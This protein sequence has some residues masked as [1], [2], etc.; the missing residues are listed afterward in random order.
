MGYMA[1]NSPTVA[2]TDDNNVGTAGGA[3]PFITAETAVKGFTS[4]NTWMRPFFDPIEEYERLA[5]NRPSDRI[6]AELPKVTD[7]TLAAILQEDP[8]RVIQQLA[9]GLVSSI[10]HDDYAQIADIVHRLKLLPMYNRMGTALQKHWNML[11]KARIWGRSASYTFFTSTDGQFH[12][13][14]VIPYVKD[15]IT[16]PGKVYAPDSNVVYMRSWYQKT[17]IQAIIARE[18]WMIKHRKDYKPEWNLTLLQQFLDGGVSTKSAELQT[19]AEK[20]RGADAKGYEVIHA[21]QKGK[22][23]EFYSFSPKF[24]DGATFRTKINPDPRGKIPIDFEY[25]NI[26][27]S[28]PLGRGSVESSG[29]V[30]NLIDQQ[31]Q[32][33]QFIT[34]LL[35]GPPLQVWGSDV[36]TNTLKFRPNAIWKMGTNGNNKVEPYQISNYAVQQFPN[37]Y[38]LLKSQIMNLNNSQDHSVSSSDAPGQSK[39]QAGVQAGEAR[40]GVSDNYM[41]KQHES[42]FNDQA[43]TSINLYFAEMTGDEK[44]ALKGDDL[45]EIMKTDAKKYVKD[46]VLTVPHKEINKV[47]FTFTVDASSSEVKEDLD[48]ATKLTEVLK[49]VQQSQDPE[50]RK[51]EIKITRLLINE[52]GAEGTDDIFPEQ[53]DENGQPID[54]QQQ[55]PDPAAAM[56]QMMPQIQQMVEEMIKQAMAQ[57]PAKTLGESVTWKPGDLKPTERAQALQQ[58]GIQAD[59]SPTPTPSENDAATS[60]AIDIAKTSHT[61][62][63]ADHT[64][65]F[66]A[67]QP[68][69]DPNAAQGQGQQQGGT[70]P[71][72]SQETGPDAGGQGESLDGQ[73]LSPEEQQIVHALM[74]QQ[75]SDDDIEQAIIMLRQGQPAEQV[76][77]VLR[78]KHASAR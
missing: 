2:K 13:D 70:M 66:Q 59:M 72:Q 21:F 40:L 48:N 54:A 50:V 27:L 49:L 73:Q 34:T 45:R 53:T 39:T 9:T 12:T 56:Q 11:S 42:W 10:N 44:I 23:A 3:T 24:E 14:F 15:I 36:K 46:G 20:E 26:D 55:Q 18:K 61:Q 62:A 65:A 41:R 43:E 47:T 8:K 28:N 74:Q 51:A 57:K 19:P 33:F 71:S 7:G 25:C 63:H 69:Q 1:T 30:Q 38:G 67:S 17:D 6:P 60:Q 76:M 29:G 37:N 32:M 4:A 58:V 5:R 77:Q 22:G 68:Q 64:A 16:E 31:M 78:S 75:F 35:M 52:I